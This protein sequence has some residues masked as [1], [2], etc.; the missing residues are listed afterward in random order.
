MIDVRVR[1]DHHV[2]LARAETETAVAGVR[3]FASSL[4][5]AAVQQHTRSR[6]VNDVPRAGYFSTDRAD[7]L[8][9]HAVLSSFG[10]L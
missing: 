8:N 4:K 2:D 6:G 1:K 7:E 5:E 10:H 3:F 9:S